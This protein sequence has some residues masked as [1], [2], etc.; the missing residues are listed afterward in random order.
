MLLISALVAARLSQEALSDAELHSRARFPQ[1]ECLEGTRVTLTDEIKRWVAG[2]DR[3][4]CYVSWLYGPMGVGKSALAQTLGEWA[5]RSGIL[6]AAIFLSN[7]QNDPYRIFASIA[8]QLARKDSGGPY[9][10]HIARQLVADGTL[11]RKKDLATQFKELILDPMS[12][13][14]SIPSQRELVVII[15]GLDECQGDREQC[16]ILRL[17]GKTVN[18]PRPLPIR[19]LICSRPEPDIRREVLRQFETHCLRKEVPMDS[20]ESLRDIELFIRKGFERIIQSHPDAF[21]PGE[22]WPTREIIAIIA[23]AASGLFIY[24]STIIKFIDD[25]DLVSPKAQLQIVMEFIKNSPVTAGPNLPNP[26]KPLDTL[27]HQILSRVHN[28]ILPVTLQLLGACAFHPHLPV[29]QLANLLNLTQEQFYSALRRVHSVIDVPL[30]GRASI[31]HLRFFHTSFVEFLRNP[32][33]SAPFSLNTR[34]IHTHFARA[35]FDALGKTKLF[36]AKNLPWKP[37]ES[38][39]TNA[40]SISHHILSYAA[41]HVWS[42]CINSGD[43]GDP[44]L[45]DSILDFDFT[46]LRFV[47]RRLPATQF[48]NFVE[49]LSHQVF[50]T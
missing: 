4:S 13:L 23:S 42:V 33:R 43:D 8:H 46:Q 36:Y 38:S 37:A 26:L 27:Y 5:E 30:Q 35:C 47:E 14:S 21:S 22:S 45:L 20:E 44:S 24:A 48:R 7:G 34:A 16:E 25:P 39:K 31:D 29:L 17:I 19:W 32:S 9:A 12:G 49:W 40:L 15:D 11:L 6:G 2:E 41:T 28:S 18:S 50:D 10:L 1:P 3:P